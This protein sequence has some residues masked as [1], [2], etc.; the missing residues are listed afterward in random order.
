MGLRK[1]ATVGGAVVSP[2]MAAA[3]TNN[4]MTINIDARGASTGV[5]DEIERRIED[6]MARYGVWADARVRT[7]GW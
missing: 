2:G 1:V 4:N 7:G 6:V 5:A 3:A